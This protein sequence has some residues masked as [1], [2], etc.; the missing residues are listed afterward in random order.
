[1]QNILLVLP[2]AVCA[3]GFV[4]LFSAG[5][6]LASAAGERFLVISAAAR[7]RDNAILLDLFVEP[8]EHALKAFPRLGRYVG[9]M[10]SPLYV[11]KPGFT[12]NA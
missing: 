8:L 12:V 2:S 10:P 4:G 5:G 11:K 6:C 7:F 3:C 9:Q 1:L